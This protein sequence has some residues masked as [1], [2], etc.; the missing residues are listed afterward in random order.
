VDSIREN[1]KSFALNPQFFYCTLYYQLIKNR[2][3]LKVLVVVS[4]VSIG[5]RR[6]RGVESDASD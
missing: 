6:V 2:D 5:D 1:R 3:E 4:K